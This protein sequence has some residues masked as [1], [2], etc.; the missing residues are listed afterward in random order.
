MVFT[1]VLNGLH[2]HFC[3]ALKVCTNSSN[4]S[5]SPPESFAKHEMLLRL[6]YFMSNSL[7]FA[8]I[9]NCFKIYIRMSFFHEQSASS[10]A[11]GGCIQFDDS[12]AKSVIFDQN[13][14]KIVYKMSADSEFEKI[15]KF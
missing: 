11:F 6:S 7:C 5:Y 14:A 12:P 4:D 8:P 10:P 13:L 15:L 1:L 9:L 3:T 2:A